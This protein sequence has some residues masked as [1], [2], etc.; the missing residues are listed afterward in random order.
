M[1]LRTMTCLGAVL[2]LVAC[3]GS[4]DGSGG[5]EA[6][7]PSE[8]NASSS[9]SS[10]HDVFVCRGSDKLEPV[11]MFAFDEHGVAEG[12]Q[13]RP[14]WCFIPLSSEKPIDSY[15]CSVTEAD[16]ATTTDGQLALLFI[17]F[18]GD[19]NNLRHQYNLP[20]DLVE[21]KG[22]K[23]TV[24]ILSR[25]PQDLKQPNPTSG[26]DHVECKLESV[27]FPTL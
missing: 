23:G 12:H 25:P 9:H 2:L 20:K 11:T 13:T 19:G 21:K 8:L 16:T 27:K 5:A 26:V 14:G 7:A 4:T 24:R 1:S 3:S 18:L 22:G 6:A 17:Q 10:N 15:L